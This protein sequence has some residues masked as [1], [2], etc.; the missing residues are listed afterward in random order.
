LL[1]QPPCGTIHLPAALGASYN[2]RATIV[3]VRHTLQIAALLQIIDKIAHRLLAAVRPFRQFRDPTPLHG[4]Q[5]K[6][7]RMGCTNIAKS[8]SVIPIKHMLV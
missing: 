5:P 4:K 8:G 7:I 3:W 1:D 2:L 6:N